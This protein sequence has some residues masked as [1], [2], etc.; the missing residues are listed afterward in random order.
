MAL[1]AFMPQGCFHLNFSHFRIGNSYARPLPP[2]PQSISPES[3]LLEVDYPYL[4]A[5]GY[6]IRN[7]ATDP[8][9]LLSFKEESE[10]ASY[11]ERASD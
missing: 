11:F 10:S 2:A 3:S 6:N 9:R 5:G 1:D 7:S 8:S 4:V